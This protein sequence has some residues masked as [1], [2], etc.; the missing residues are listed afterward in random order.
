MD[1]R[2]VLAHRHKVITEIDTRRL[3]GTFTDGDGTEHEVRLKF[4]V[5]DACEGRGRYVNPSIDS[6]G[7]SGDDFAEDP[8]FAEDYFS[9]VHDVCC[10]QCDGER[11]VAVVDPDRN[12]KE[13]VA[14]IEE[15]EQDAWADA[16]NSVRERE[17][18]Y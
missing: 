17:M 18:G 1:F 11:L 10:R 7:L 9:G 5:C 16:R 14:Q 6:H 15:A 8:D 3:V 4:E 12:S 2:D 13:M